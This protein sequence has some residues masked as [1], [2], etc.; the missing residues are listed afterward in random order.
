MSR[1]N[2]AG[3]APGVSA[4]AEGS[5]SRAKTRSALA[6]AIAQ[7][8]GNWEIDLSGDMILSAPTRNP[9]VAA[10]PSSTPVTAGLAA[11]QMIRVSTSPPNSSLT[12]LVI[13][14]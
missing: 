9:I 7:E 1:S 8:A 10:A 11:A 13:E 3:A 6:C 14:E 2:R 12:G 4:S 5:S